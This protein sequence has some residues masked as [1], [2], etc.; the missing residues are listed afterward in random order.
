[1]LSFGIV[2]RTFKREPQRRI[3]AVTKLTSRCDSHAPLLGLGRAR[4]NA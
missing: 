2:G 1:L 3:A 4:Q